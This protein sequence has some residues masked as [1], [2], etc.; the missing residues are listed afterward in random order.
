MENQSYILDQ[1]ELSLDS[2]IDQQNIIGLG[3]F[4]FLNVI[5]LGL[6]GMWWIYKSWRFF[7][8]KEKSN[9]MPAVRTILSLFF[10]IAL[11][12]RILNYAQEK[13][14][15]KSYSSIFLFIGFLVFNLLS[16]L[17]E[18]YLLISIFSLVYLIPPFLALNYAKRN[19]KVV[20]VYEQT[21]FNTRQIILIVAGSIFWALLILGFSS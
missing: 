2:N 15:T 12:Q 3:Q 10:L 1:D 14:Y 4:I 11:F 17:P 19:S 21:S 5:T 20:A 16:Y 9:L 13:G 7:Q 8:Q 6:Y 18:P